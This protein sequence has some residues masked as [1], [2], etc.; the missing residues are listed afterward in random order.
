MDADRHLN[1]E[2]A[3]APLVDTLKGVAAQPI[4]WYP[5][6][7]CGPLARQGGA[8]RGCGRRVLGRQLGAGVGVC[9]LVGR[10]AAAGVAAGLIHWPWPSA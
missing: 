4:V 2:Q 6:S 5:L 7:V 3:R 1:T 10:P 9:L 8:R